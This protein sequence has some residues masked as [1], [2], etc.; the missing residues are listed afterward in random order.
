MQ[1]LTTHDQ[2]LLALPATWKVENVLLFMSGKQIEIHP[3][4]TGKKVDCPECGTSS[5]INDKAP[6][7][8][9]RYLDM[10]QYET[11]FVA[12]VP[13]SEGK[14]CGVKTVKVPRADRHSRYTLLFEGVAV[15]FLQHC[16]SIQAA[17]KLLRLSWH[18]TNEIMSRAVKRG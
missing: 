7:Q 18:A 14:Q 12:R 11:I 10:V 6:E 9:W 3:E 16:S 8:R 17:S 15:A 4:Y 1:S 2:Q 5:G 13:R